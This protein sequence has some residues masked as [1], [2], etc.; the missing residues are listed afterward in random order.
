MKNKIQNACP[1]CCSDEVKKVID[2]SQVPVHCNRLYSNR[3]DA[4]KAPRGDIQLG[5][6]NTCGHI[7]NMTFDER[8]MEYAPHYENSLHFSP[9]FQEYI[10]A[11]AKRLIDSYGLHDKDVIEIGC[12]NGDFLTLLCKLGANRGIGFD[13]AYEPGRGVGSVSPGL[14][15]KVIQDFY[16]ERYAN[17]AAD[18]ICC[19]HVLEHIGFPRD[20]LKSIRRAVGGRLDTVIF[21]EVPN[22]MFSLHDLGIWDLIYEHCG[23]FSAASLDYLF[24]SSGFAVKELDKAFAGQFIFVDALPVEESL[25][26]VENP[27]NDHEALVSD[28][29]SFSRRYNEKVEEWRTALEETR[30]GKQHVVAWGAGSKGVTFLN[31]LGLQDQVEYVVDVNPHK[32]RMYVAGTG[33]KI[34]PPEFLKKYSPDKIIVMNPIYLDEIRRIT[35][36]LNVTADFVTV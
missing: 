25:L 30:Y 16:S 2:I 5:F 15:F 32:Q 35:L 4:L 10:E 24:K 9:R 28:V 7:Y 8:L 27:L 29:T 19:R 6:C 17:Y 14:K 34:V 33:Q 12:G 36:N 20:F 13:P 11:Q 18:L 26:S 23:Y 21:F 22:V 1:V 3:D 31:T